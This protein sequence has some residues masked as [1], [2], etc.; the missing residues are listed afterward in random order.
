[1]K[2]DFDFR[3]S[4]CTTSKLRISLGLVG[5]IEAIR[6]KLN[7]RIEIVKG[8]YCGSCFECR[9]TSYG[10]K[11]DF[12][13]IGIAADIRVEN[14]ENID[15]FHFIE[16]SFPEVKGLGLNLDTGHV[17]ID[18]RKED[19]RSIW[20]EVDKQWIEI[21]DQNALNTFLHQTLTPLL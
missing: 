8:F 17:H 11:R 20:V 1:M 18:T 21:D 9:D 3:C 2:R 4:E 12:H 10:I 7:K 6:A 5:I 14:M 16:N 13:C 15:L 19:E